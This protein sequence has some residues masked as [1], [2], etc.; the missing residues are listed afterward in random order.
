MVVVNS[1]CPKCGLPLTVPARADEL[2]Q[3]ATVEVDAPQHCASH[4][5]D[6]PSRG[7]A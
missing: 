4:C 6:I 1:V 3:A 2:A 7:A 5:D